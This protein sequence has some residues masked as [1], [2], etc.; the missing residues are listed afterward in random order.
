MVLAASGAFHRSAIMCTHR[1]SI[2]ADCGYSSLSIMFLLTDS[3][4]RARTSGSSHVWQNVARFWRALPSSISSSDTTWNAS[5][6]RRLVAGELVLRHRLGQVAPDEHAV[7]HLVPDS[8]T[9]MQRHG[10]HPSCSRPAPALAPG[11]AG[12]RRPARHMG[13]RLPCL[14]LASLAS[15][16]CYGW[17]TG[18]L[19]SSSTQTAL[20]ISVWR[21]P[22]L[23][24]RASMSTKP[25]PDSSSVSGRAWP[26]LVRIGVVHLDQQRR[27]LRVQ[28][29]CHGER[30]GPRV[31]QHVADQ[32]GDEQY[33]GLLQVCHLPHRQG[34]AG[35]LPRQTCRPPG[36]GQG[37]GHLPGHVFAPIRKSTA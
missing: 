29:Q 16:P 36:R 1:R 24:A 11:S 34:V 26:R 15:I 17:L 35:R 30:P 6:G 22:H 13:P 3:A 7:R 9:L 33:R 5:A 8:V 2:S 12:V 21:T 32:F 18:C 10:P 20:P 27:H 37:H 28:E 31:P 25:N 4:I 19:A 23:P 14:R